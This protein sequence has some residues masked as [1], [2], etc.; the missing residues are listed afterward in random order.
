MSVLDVKPNNQKYK[1]FIMTIEKG[2]AM[3]VIKDGIEV[4]LVPVNIGLS[5]NREV[6]VWRV[7]LYYQPPACIAEEDAW[8]ESFMKEVSRRLEG[9]QK[10]VMFD[11]GMAN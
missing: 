2:K 4:E 7:E 10:V 3:K 6:G 5:M 11:V 1:Y 9:E 8:M